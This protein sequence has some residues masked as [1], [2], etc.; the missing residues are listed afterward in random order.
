MKSAFIMNIASARAKQPYNSPGTMMLF[1][2]LALCTIALAAPP[3]LQ[4]FTCT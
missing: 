3:A 4:G 1:I 2:L